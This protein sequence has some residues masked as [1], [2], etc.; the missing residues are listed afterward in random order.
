[1]VDV[2]D[3]IGVVDSIAVVEEEV[4]TESDAVSEDG[5]SIIDMVGSEDVA[6]E[7]MTEVEARA[8]EDARDVGKEERFKVVQ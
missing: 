5:S 2:S 4:E 8:K 1:M 3:V 7:N 6:S